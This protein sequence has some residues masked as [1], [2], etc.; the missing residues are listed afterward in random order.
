MVVAALGPFP[1]VMNLETVTGPA[2]SDRA[3]PLV[4][5][6]HE[7]SD[8]G[9]NGFGLMGHPDRTVSVGPDETDF[10]VTEDPFQ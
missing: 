2:A 3:L 1:N 4:S 10:A 5:L 7:S 8:R 6:Q 9:C